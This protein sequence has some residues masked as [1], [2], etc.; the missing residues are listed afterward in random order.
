LVTRKEEASPP[1]LVWR[2]SE[3]AP[4][5]EWVDASRAEE[6][7]ASPL[8]EV[9]SGGWVISSY[10]L[11]QGSDTSEVEDTIPGELFDE[12]FPASK[13]DPTAP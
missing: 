6:P 3:R 1:K 13:K 8:P 11:L 4:M 9:S 7:A 2:I 12:L 5:G 10:D